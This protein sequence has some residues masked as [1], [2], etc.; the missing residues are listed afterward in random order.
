MQTAGLGL[1]RNRHGNQFHTRIHIPRDLTGVLGKREIR[2]SLGTEVRRSAIAAARLLHAGKIAAFDKL[3]AAM[4][5]D[6]I[7]ASSPEEREQ[8]RV[9]LLE[10]IRQRLEVRQPHH[11]E[12][13]AR[14]AQ[15]A[16]EQA[17]LLAKLDGQVAALEALEEGKHP[18]IPSTA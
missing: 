8:Q 4:C 10:I 3:R 17:Q 14:F 5:E 1:C 7:L 15:E 11:P 12:D 16:D 2:I 6:K 9:R 13:A 18:A